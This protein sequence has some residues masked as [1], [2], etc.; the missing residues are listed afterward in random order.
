MT[1]IMAGFNPKLDL[2]LERVVDVSPELIWKAWTVPEHLMP[3]FCPKPWQVTEC[4]I[5]LRPGGIFRTVMKG[6]DMPGQESIGCFLEIVEN[7]KL[8]WTD[9]LGK[10]YRPNVVANPCIEGHFTAFLYLTPCEDGTKYTVI[11]R[12]GDETN[13]KNHKERGFEDGWGTALTQLVDY[14]KGF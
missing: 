4:T 12:H 1:D 3:W 6:P 7:R 14:V 9:A 5:D 8:V 13:Y 2:K 11:A 10:D